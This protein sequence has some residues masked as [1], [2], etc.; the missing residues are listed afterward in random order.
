VR[1]IYAMTG[2][3]INDVYLTDLDTLYGYGSYLSADAPYSVTGYLRNFRVTG[4]R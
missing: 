2:R 3:S 1:G 4:G